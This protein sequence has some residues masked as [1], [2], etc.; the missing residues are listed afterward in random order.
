MPVI[1]NF[2]F[3]QALSVAEAAAVLLGQKVA[4]QAGAPVPGG[5]LIHE[6]RTALATLQT[7][8]RT[9]AN[10]RIRGAARH[11]LNAY[12]GLDVD[13]HPELLHSTSLTAPAAAIR[14]VS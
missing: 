2:D 7:A 4:Q 8:A 14:R 13:V 5:I 6:P 12:F 10:P 3:A 11:A 9:A 1:T